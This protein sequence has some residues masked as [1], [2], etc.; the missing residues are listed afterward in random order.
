M[1]HTSAIYAIRKSNIGSNVAINY[2]SPI[3]IVRG[4]GSY[5]YDDKDQQYLDGVNNVAHVG[6]CHPS[7]VEAVSTQ[8]SQL[9]TNS[10][11][12]HHAITDYSIELLATLPKSA[13]WRIFMTNSG[14]E[15]NDLALRIAIESSALKQLNAPGSQPATHV[16]VMASAYHGHLTSMVDISPYKFWAPGGHGRKAHVHVIPVPDAYRGTNLDGRK[17]ALAAIASAK[18]AGGK[19]CAFYAESILSCGG[20]VIFPSGY[21]SSIYEVMREH[22]AACIADEVQCGFGRVGTHFWGFETQGVI[23]DMLVIGKS[24]GNGYPVSALVATKSLADDFAARGLSYF[25]TYGGSTGACVAAL[26]TLRVVLRDDLQSRGHEVGQYLLA[27]LRGLLFS[28]D[29]NQKI[30]YDFVGDVRG[31]G[32]MVGIEVV[33]SVESKHPA[34]MMA[35]W[36]KEAMK[37]RRVLLSTDGP[38]DNVIKMKPPMSWGR[39]EVDLLVQQ[40]S[41][42]LKEDLTPTARAKV[43]R[44]EEK[45]LGTLL[46]LMERY[47]EDEV[48][49]YACL[50]HEETFRFSK[51]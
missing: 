41:E 34:P 43:E 9:N 27:A 37:T 45:H 15:S 33:T 22:G 44:E 23:P 32:L 28:R 24:M 39:A 35:K 40:L 19:I 26:S 49:M 17:S 4:Q 48:R 2:S 50:V 11:Y 20:Q 3:H 30:I 7:V 42:S 18:Q 21:L 5:L 12:L 29:L 14:S 6:H 13:E 46:P 38:Y 47:R 51:L 16:A 8:L 10:R 36:I 25:N 31:I 1:D